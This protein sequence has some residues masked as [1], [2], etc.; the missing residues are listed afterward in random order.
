MSEHHLSHS[1]LVDATPEAVYDL[2]TDVARTG[3]WSPVCR[4]AWWEEGQGPRAGAWFGGRNEI[5]GRTWET[6]SQVVVAERG[7]EF[8]W[9]VEGRYVVWAYLM[10]AVGEPGAVRTELTE[11]WDLNE[12]TEQRFADT[13][14]DRAEELLEQRRQ[15]ARVGIPA[16]LTTLKGVLEGSTD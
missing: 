13:Y 10:R 8:R 11:T 15:E 16:T 7:R 1:I 9:Q 6:R 5:P 12:A 14:G 3:E 4:A 2:V